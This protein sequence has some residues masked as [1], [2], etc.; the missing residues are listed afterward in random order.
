MNIWILLVAYQLKHFVADYLLQTHYMLGKFREKGWVLPLLAHVSVHA[1]FTATIAI[2]FGRMDIALQLALFDGFAH[3]VLDRIK[4]SP[5]L[6]GRWKP[7]SA[8]GYMTA[9]KDGETAKL[10]SNQRFWWSIGV[11]QMV[12]HLT[13]YVCIFAI[14]RM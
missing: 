6:M 11:D 10:R 8:I 1:V 14:L 3:F 13:H 5:S 4:A 12:H 7:L 9:Y 2:A